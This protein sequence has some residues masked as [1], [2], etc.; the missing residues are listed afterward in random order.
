MFGDSGVQ[1]AQGK[2][3]VSIHGGAFGLVIPKGYRT[4]KGLGEMEKAL[5]RAVDVVSKNT[6]GV[7]QP[8][9]EKSTL[10]MR[11]AVEAV[12]HMEDDPEF[13]AGVGSVLT[14]TGGIEMEAAV[15][16]GNTEDSGGCCGVGTFTN[17]I[18]LAEL[19]RTR[20]DHT[21]LGYDGVEELG[22]EWGLKS[23]T[24]DYFVQAREEKRRQRLEELAASEG[25]NDHEVDAK[26]ILLVSYE[27]TSSIW[28]PIL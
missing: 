10:A 17:P 20:T 6:P 23:E 26:V 22:R 8:W 19:V 4:E 14:T 2:W 9:S 15:M 3:S 27:R 12:V 1:M 24:R 16:E 28:Y 18:L 11:A 25:A 5:D 21:L 7:L 13:N